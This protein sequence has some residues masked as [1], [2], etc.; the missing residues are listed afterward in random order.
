MSVFLLFLL[1]LLIIVNGFFVAAEFSLVRSRA[2]KIKEMAGEGSRGAE[3]AL[4]EIE[5]IDEYL[6]AAQ[7]G[8]P[9]ASIGPGS[10]GEPRVAELLEPLFGNAVSHGLAVAIS[11]GIAY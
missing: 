10:L 7:V 6:S 3:L 4:R 5:S 11:V 2:A 8:I 9:M 1:F